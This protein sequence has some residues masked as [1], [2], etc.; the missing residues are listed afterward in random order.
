MIRLQGFGLHTG[1]EASVTLVAEPGPLRLERGG[2]ARE[3]GDFRVAATRRATDIACDAFAVAT[4]EH[5][6]AAFAGLGVRAGCRVVVEGP[7]GELPLLDGAAL[8]WMRALETLGFE[9][10]AGASLRVVKAGIVEVE[11]STYAFEPSA[12]TRV[13]VEVDLPPSCARAAS[14]DGGPFERIAAARTFATEADVEALARDG[15]A[16]HVDPASVLVV[17][18]DA[19]R[20][21]GD[22]APDEPARHKLL[23]LVGDAFLHGGPPVGR[24]AATRPGHARN[25]VAFTR[26]RAMGLVAG[27]ALL[28]ALPATARADEPAR[29]PLLFDLTHHDTEIMM[30]TT[31]ASVSYND[32]A[33]QGATYIRVDRLSAE[34]PIAPARWYVGAA[35]DAALGHDDDG[36]ARFVSGNPEIWGRGVWNAAYGLS[37]GGGFSLVIPTKSFG[38]SDPA[39]AVALAALDVR[40]WERASFDPDNATLRPFLDIRLVTGP[41]TVCYRQG[42]EIATDFGDTNFRF[43]A[44]GIVYFAIRF[45]PLVTAGLDLAEY[46]HLESGLDDDQRAY[47]A[48]GAHV[49]LD[50]KS[51][52]PSLGLMTNIGSPL[53][54]ISHIGTPFTNAPTSFVGVHFSLDFPIHLKEE[55]ARPRPR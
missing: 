40:G 36:T 44:V 39:A 34:I 25:H 41:V 47:F 53:D 5:L 7:A 29:P 20:G 33:A 17:T 4:V 49:S 54:T 46:Y 52:R 14:W 43:A 50:M 13:E 28:L 10:T 22:I 18:S 2:I 11:G 30:E 45:S 26:A 55:R 35:Y 27:A 37:F 38:P 23:D 6:F 12:T 1:A 3:M 8:A 24:L 19:I 9:P 15:L 51:F 16:R 21:V 31:L 48:V 42:L 32:A